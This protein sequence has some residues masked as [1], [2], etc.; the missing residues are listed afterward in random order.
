M[1]IDRGSTKKRRE[2]N[3]KERKIKSIGSQKL[4]RKHNKQKPRRLTMEEL[5]LTMPD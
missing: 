4:T 1:Q 5:W 3:E 2:R